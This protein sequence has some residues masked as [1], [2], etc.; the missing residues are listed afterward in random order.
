MRFG[1]N[2][3]IKKL[4]INDSGTLDAIVEANLFH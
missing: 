3:N 1:S 4:K 2:T